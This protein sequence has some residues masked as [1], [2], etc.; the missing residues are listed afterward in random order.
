MTFIKIVSASDIT[1]SYIPKMKHSIFDSLLTVGKWLTSGVAPDTFEKIEETGRTKSY[2]LLKGALK[3]SIEKPDTKLGDEEFAKVLKE[4]RVKA[5]KLDNKEFALY[6]L[7]ANQVNKDNIA[8]YD[9]VVSHPGIPNNSDFGKYK[10]AIRDHI[11]TT[12][13]N[14]TNEIDTV[15]SYNALKRI[16][17][18]PIL[19]ENPNI[20][21]NLNQFVRIYT[22]YDDK[23]VEK[24]LNEFRLRNNSNV[25]KYFRYYT[26]L[27]FSNAEKVSSETELNAKLELINKLILNRHANNKEVQA[28][29]GHMIRLTK[30]PEQ[31]PLW[32]KFLNSRYF[33]SNQT[34]IEH[35]RNAVGAADTKE[36]AE[37]MTNGWEFLM[38][39]MNIKKAYNI[40][41]TMCSSEY[42]EFTRLDKMREI[43]YL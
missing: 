10:E 15:L 14:D 4:V 42:P 23:L 13:I 29:A 8:L 20:A 11:L 43:I 24:V 35:L 22:P 9:L 18:N 5:E 38:Q 1:G 28:E 33:I 6:V 40:Y 41:E 25:T 12:F 21:E 32:Q 17:D 36:K 19:S 34:I 3:R 30:I 16:L 31:L 26:D 7:D 39:N 2:N 27:A 37:I